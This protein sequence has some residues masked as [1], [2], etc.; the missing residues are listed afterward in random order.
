MPVSPE[1]TQNILLGASSIGLGLWA[2]WERVQKA[3]LQ[4]ANTDATV[5]VSGAQEQMFKLM[6][7]RLT[8]LETDYNNL[9]AELMEERKHSRVLD[10]KV[11]QYQIHMMKLDAL[12]RE[13]G[14]TP[15]PFELL[16]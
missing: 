7:S 14:I 9:R 1:V 8:A 5:S 12:L 13:K 11:Q 15:P 6:T 3:R 10:I 2:V 4:K 16:T